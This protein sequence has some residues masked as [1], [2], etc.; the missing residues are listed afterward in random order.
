M[1]K[2]EDLKYK[3]VARLKEGDILISTVWLGL[4]HGFGKRRLIFES[5]V[6]GGPYDQLQWRYSSEEEAQK[7]HDILVRA[8]RENL[9]PRSCASWSHDKN[10]P[11]NEIPVFIHNAFHRVQ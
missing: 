5:M 3:E 4:D 6:F 11:T 7:G 2:F 10:N 9:D 8:F 1:F